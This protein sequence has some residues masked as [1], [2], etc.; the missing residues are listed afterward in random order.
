[1]DSVMGMWQQMSKKMKDNF[2]ISEHLAGECSYICTDIYEKS[3]TEFPIQHIAE[4]E[5]VI[6]KIVD[7]SPSTS[8][9]YLN[10]LT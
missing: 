6:L 5:E 7:N 9:E 8:A 1:M 10:K 4:K 3:T 2:G